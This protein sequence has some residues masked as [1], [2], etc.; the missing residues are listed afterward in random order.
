MVLFLPPFPFD[1]ALSKQKIKSRFHGS[2]LFDF[3]NEFKKEIFKPFGN[4]D[5]DKAYQ[6]KEAN[7]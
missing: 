7:S 6:R 4:F 5:H 1:S 3:I 2:L